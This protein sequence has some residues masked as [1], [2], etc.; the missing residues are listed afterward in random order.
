MVLNILQTNLHR[1]DS[2]RLSTKFNEE[3]PIQ[4]RFIAFELNNLAKD[5]TSDAYSCLCFDANLQE[6]T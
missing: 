3:G 4:V 2:L 6:M 5:E 1:H